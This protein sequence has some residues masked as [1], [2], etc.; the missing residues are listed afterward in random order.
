MEEFILTLSKG[1]VTKLKLLQVYIKVKE[2]LDIPINVL[3]QDKINLILETDPKV[4]E[5]EVFFTEFINAFSETFYNKKPKEDE[6][7]K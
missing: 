4:A 5:A 6:H 7:T 2:D 1:T 3:I